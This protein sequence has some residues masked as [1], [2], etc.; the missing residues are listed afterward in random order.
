MIEGMY[1]RLDKARMT[2]VEK[3]ERQITF[4]NGKDWYDVEADEVDLRKVEDATITGNR[5]K[6]VTWEQWG[7]VVERGRP[8]SLVLTKLNPA[9]TKARAPGPG[10]I[11]KTDWK[12]FA[13]KRL[14]NRKVVLHTDGARSYN[15]TVD[16]M[17]HDK[18]IHKK[19]QVC[20]RRQTSWVKPK[21][22][23]IFKHVVDDG[24]V[25][26]VKGGTQ[27][28][29]RFWSTLRTHLRGCASSPESAALRRRI[30]SAQWA[31]WNRSKDLWLETGNMVQSIR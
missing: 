6:P 14:K 27:I 23:K 31:Y 15:I 19:K 4:G 24:K 30:R 18:V 11:R 2:F 10:P 25:L 29:D 17:L 7:G 8:Q 16:G 1:T 3:T 12:P 20:V 21:F 26:Y 13:T 9:V 22:S 5:T 28:I